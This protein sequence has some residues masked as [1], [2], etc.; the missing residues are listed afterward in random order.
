MLQ[1]NRLHLGHDPRRKRAEKN[2]ASTASAASSRFAIRFRRAKAQRSKG[3][4]NVD[5]LA[6]FVSLALCAFATLRLCAGHA[7]TK[8][9]TQV[10]R[11]ES[12]M[13]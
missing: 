2:V 10:L 11:R 8:Q 4:K 6:I 13:G 12:L 9:K 3:A 7:P 1:A 5:L